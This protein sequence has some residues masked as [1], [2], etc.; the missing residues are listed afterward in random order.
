[1]RLSCA[2]AE[3]YSSSHTSNCTLPFLSSD[4]TSPN[5]ALEYAVYNNTTPRQTIKS[6]LLRFLRILSII[7]FPAVLLQNTLQIDT[8]MTLEVCR[9][10][11]VQSVSPILWRVSSSFHIQLK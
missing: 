5:Q 3:I 2:N 9:P 1:M 11:K 7:M 10:F 4:S 8:H 6:N